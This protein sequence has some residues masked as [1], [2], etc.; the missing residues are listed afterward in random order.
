MQAKTQF[1]RFKIGE[2]Y[3]QKQPIILSVDNYE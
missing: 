1:D 3:K 2:V